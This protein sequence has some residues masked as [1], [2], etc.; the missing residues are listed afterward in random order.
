MS[1]EEAVGV[2]PNGD[3]QVSHGDAAN[4]LPTLAAGTF[5]L[6]LS[7]PPHALGRFDWDHELPSELIL[8]ELRRVLKPG[9]RLV[10]IA[11]DRTCHRLAT[12]VENAGFE[13]EGMAAWVFA[14]GRPRNATA[15]KPAFQPII[16]AH[17]PG[18]L[19]QTTIDEARIPWRDDRDRKQA[20]RA[21]TLTKAR[22]RAYG[23]DLDRTTSYEPDPRGRWPSNVLG[24]D[25][26][27]AVLR[28]PGG[29]LLG[30][31]KNWV[32][33][34]LDEAAEAVDVWP[35]WKLRPEVRAPLYHPLGAELALSKKSS[36]VATRVRRPSPK[37]VSQP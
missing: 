20:S 18:P 5:D 11:D 13:I 2:P 16:V 33:E 6:V 36:Q 32:N 12:A 30:M 27:L 29:R 34:V 28:V 1:V 17:A 35:D 8:R 25:G 31:R 14:D 23:D 19:V 10:F 24:T 9:G 15:P 37:A 26:V 7:D 22:R 21:K 4:V 3:V